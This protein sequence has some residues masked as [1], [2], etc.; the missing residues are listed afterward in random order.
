MAPEK[1]NGDPEHHK[2]DIW[3][4]GVFMYTLLCG[5]PPFD[6]GNKHHLFE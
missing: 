4:I 5:Y 3:S 1:V 6:G 2:S